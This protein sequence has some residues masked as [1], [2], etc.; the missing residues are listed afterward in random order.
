MIKC[1]VLGSGSKGNCVYI[2]VNGEH[3]LLDA[4]LS[5]KRIKAGLAP[6]L[7]EDINIICIT[8]QHNDHI[9]SLKGLQK[10]NSRL[11]II[12]KE[13]INNDKQYKII[14][15]TADH[16]VPCLNFRIN[17]LKHN[18]SLLYITDTGTI[19]CD[20]LKYLVKPANIIICEMNHDIDL[21]LK[22]NKYADELKIRIGETHLSNDQTVDLLSLICTDKLEYF[23][24]F[25]LSEQNN[26]PAYAEYEAKTAIEQIAPG[27]KIIIAE[28]NEPTGMM[29]V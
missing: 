5:L 14:P 17:D 19:F 15:F 2:N 28:Q 3:M 24:A 16:D 25:H 18:N 1:K 21:L 29:F 20:S 26:S 6:V 11:K 4:G 27:C 7:T 12:T 10:R 8:H 13:T 9:R 22:N 23:I